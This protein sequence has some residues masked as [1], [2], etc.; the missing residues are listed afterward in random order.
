M[1]LPLGWVAAIG[2]IVILSHFPD[3]V[4]A[5]AKAEGEAEEEPVAA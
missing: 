4:V 5:Q 1:R 3:K 2:D